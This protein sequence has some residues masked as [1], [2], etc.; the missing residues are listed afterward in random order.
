VF[1]DTLIVED[2]RPGRRGEAVAL[3]R[4]RLARWTSR[5]DRE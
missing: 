4:A 3:S 2:I 5:R 1:E